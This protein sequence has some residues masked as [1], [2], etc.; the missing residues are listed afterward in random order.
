[1]VRLYLEYCHT[2][3]HPRT[4]AQMKTIEGVLRRASKH[5]RTERPPLQRA[6]STLKATVDALQIPP[7]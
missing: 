4:I 5:T 6:T 7:R 2:V 3:T 1:M